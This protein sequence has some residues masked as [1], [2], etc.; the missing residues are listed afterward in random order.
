MFYFNTASSLDQAMKEL[1]LDPLIYDSDIEG[2]VKPVD[3]SSTS[4]SSVEDV[5]RFRFF[6]CDHMF[7][8]EP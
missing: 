8:G 3:Y 7:Q 5:V 1:A 2:N 4:G 6:K